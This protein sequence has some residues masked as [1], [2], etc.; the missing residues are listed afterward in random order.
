MNGWGTTRHASYVLSLS[1]R[2]MKIAASIGSLLKLAILCGAIYALVIWKFNGPENTGNSA[3]AEQACADAI[4]GRF[5][6]SPVNV[7]AVSKSDK[8]YVVRASITLPNGNPAKVYCL[9]NKFGGVE[10][11]RINER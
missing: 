9:T 3:Y 7:Y 10:E 1:E 11:I 6:A 4:G 8:G 5:D 2:P